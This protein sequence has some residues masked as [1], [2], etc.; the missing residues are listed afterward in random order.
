[1][2][3]CLVVGKQ[4]SLCHCLKIL[5]VTNYLCQYGDLLP[6]ESWSSGM[7]DNFILTLSITKDPHDGKLCSHS[8]TLMIMSL[9]T[10]SKKDA[11]QR[12]LP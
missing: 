2:V 11:L 10:P 5:L 12:L 6:E 9:L 4:Q 1:M 7:V 8:T 3:T